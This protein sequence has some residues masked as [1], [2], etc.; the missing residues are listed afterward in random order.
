MAGEFT[1]KS[2]SDAAASSLPW[3]VIVTVCVVAITM[4]ISVLA[5]FALGRMR[6]WGS[7]ILATGIFL[8]ALAFYLERKRRSLLG[9]MSQPATATSA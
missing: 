5:A 9:R 7:S 8:I 4:V 2:Q 1:L 6:F 3:M